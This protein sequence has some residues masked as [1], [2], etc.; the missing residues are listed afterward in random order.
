MV[1]GNIYD[2]LTFGL[3][4]CQTLLCATNLSY[5]E[6]FNQ[7]SSH[8]PVEERTR[9]PPRNNFADATLLKHSF[10]SVVQVSEVNGDS[11]IDMH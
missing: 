5:E 11:V 9:C 4:N 8:P 2:V 3:S 1:I 7:T 10:G 6:V